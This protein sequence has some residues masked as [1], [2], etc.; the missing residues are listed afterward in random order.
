MKEIIKFIY[1]FLIYRIFFIFPVKKN[2]IIFSSYYGKSYSC[3][4]KMICEY[5]LKNNLDYE[6]IYV[7]NNNNNNN[8]DK[9]KFVKRGSLQY[10]FYFA[11]SKYRISNCQESYYLKPRKKMIYLQTWH[12]T[13][14]KK[15]AQDIIGKQFYKIKKEWKIEA[16]YWNY[17]IVSNEGLNELFKKAFEIEKCK[18]I[19]CNYPRNEIFKENN[20]IHKIKDELANYGLDK[21]K[22]IILYAPTFRDGEKIFKLNLSEKFIE[23]IT[24]KYNF[25]FRAHS[26]I[27]KSFLD[28]KIIDVS[29]YD[30]I[31]ELYLVTDILITDYSSVFFDF[32]LLEKP[33]IFYPYDIIK[34]GSILRGFYYPYNIV[35]PG[36]IVLNEEN[37]LLEI[38]NLE[39]N[40]D[41][42][43]IKKFNK[44]FNNNFAVNSI[45]KILKEIKII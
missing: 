6:I 3:N 26:N 23:Q 20:R 11:T 14:L 44:K 43:K 34:Y 39:K 22:K 29:K 41:K 2:R 10:L 28:K 35:V 19:N 30:D 4:P 8:R 37:L 12:G 33:M 18:I 32:A 24:K 16:S 42:E 31:N 15:I 1:F 9:I 27:E 25:L 36:P 21:D 17:L 40:F 5:I 7:L 38:L 45:E 13:P